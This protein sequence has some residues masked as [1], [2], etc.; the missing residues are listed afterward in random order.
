[1]AGPVGVQIFGPSTVDGLVKVNIYVAGGFTG[2]PLQNPMT[3]T[4]DIIYASDNSGTPSR[5]SIGTTNQV[6]YVT[7]GL[8]SWTTLTSSF[9]SDFNTAVNGLITTGLTNY[10][11]NS[12]LST[13]LIG[14]VTNSSLTSTL[15]GYATTSGVTSSLANYL[16]LI[17]GTMSG[18]INMGANKI[19]NLT[20]GSSASDAVRFDQ[21][22]V[23]PANASGVLTNNGSGS[24]SWGNVGGLYNTA[25]TYGNIPFSTGSGT[26]SFT[27][28][29]SNGQYLA[30]VSNT[31][32]WSVWG[33]TYTSSILQTTYWASA[34]QIRYRKDPAGMVYIVGVLQWLGS[35]GSITS[36]VN[37][38]T[39]HF[40]IPFSP[41]GV[42]TTV[43]NNNSHYTMA[44]YIDSL[45]NLTI[46]GNAATNDY[47]TLDGIS[48]TTL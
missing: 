11:T 9:I 47:I 48:Y 8:P 42:Y 10:V 41:S 15:S 39:F 43:T 6:L 44:A 22:V 26:Y 19:T 24:L 20:A 30:L 13:T 18:G 25:A 12:A 1:M 23:F 37:E 31:P 2:T 16:P 40:P 46:I 35:S 34:S 3:T 28:T 21:I 32:V 17:G 5:K 27:A 14:Y 33:G 45:G 38:S 7:G 36:T 4:G 29:G